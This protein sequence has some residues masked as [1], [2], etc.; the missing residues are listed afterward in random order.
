[1][2]DKE[3]FQKVLGLSPWYVVSYEFSPDEGARRY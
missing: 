3:L 2:K 1:M